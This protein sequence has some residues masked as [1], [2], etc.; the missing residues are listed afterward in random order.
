MCDVTRSWRGKSGVVGDNEMGTY[1]FG[2][3]LNKKNT[4]LYIYLNNA[5]YPPLILL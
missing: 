1:Q 5:L 2:G 3:N 4:V